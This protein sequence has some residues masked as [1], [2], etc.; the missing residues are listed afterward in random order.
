M[1]IK[2]KVIDETPFIT[3]T[4]KETDEGAIDVILVHYLAERIGEIKPGDD[5]R[6]WA[7]HD[8]SKLPSDLGPNIIPALKHFNF[9][10]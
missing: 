4:R 8:L 3:H 1:G 6:E 10:K 2:I 9:I 7:W 5:I